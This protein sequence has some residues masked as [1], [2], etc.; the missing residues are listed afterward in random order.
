ME[1]DMEQALTAVQILFYSLGG[2]GLFF[3]GIGTLW[4]VDVYKKKSE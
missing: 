4:F 1:G 3:M 2:L